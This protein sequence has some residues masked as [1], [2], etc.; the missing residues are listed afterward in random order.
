MNKQTA[1]TVLLVEPLC[2]GFNEESAGY[3]MLQPSGLSGEEI[4]I[5][6]RQELLAV[7]STLKEKGVNVILVKDD[8]LQK[9]PSSVFVADWVTFHEDSRLVAYPLAAQNRKAERR[10]EIL[11]V[12]VDNG[13]PIYDIV[14][15]SA[16]ENE[17]RFLHGA[18]SLVFDRANKVAYAALSGAADKDVVA[19]VCARLDYQLVAFSASRTVGGVRLPIC[20]TSHVLSLAD[21]YV[22]VCLNSIDDQEE[23]ALL[24]QSFEKTG[25]TVIE[26]T[27]E[28]V[29]SYAGS[30]LQLESVSGKHFLLTSSAAYNSFTDHQKKRLESFNDILTVDISTIEKVGGSSIRSI[31]SE[32]FLPK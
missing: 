1:N 6:A 4:S 15:V 24:C 12:I 22:L 3:Y 19:D 8:Q 10:G 17:G 5:K 16:S 18:A 31:V 7:A 21:K 28:Q 11:N 20:F 26:I 2:F 14:D 27:Q 23:K 9:T 32:I 30:V 29:A 25:K 13:F